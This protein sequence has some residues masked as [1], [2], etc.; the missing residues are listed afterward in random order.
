T[1]WDFKLLLGS[2]NNGVM[3]T[4]GGVLFASSREGNLIALDTKT[5]KPLWRDQTRGNMTAS[6]MNF[7]VDGR[8]FIAV[9]SRDSIFFF[10]FPPSK[11]KAKL[12]RLIAVPC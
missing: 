3:A 2:N 6:P 5:G 12:G 9:P 11:V 7:G 8:H 10:L 1:M 4:A